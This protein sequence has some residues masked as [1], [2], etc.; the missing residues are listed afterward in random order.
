MIR[1]FYF[2][3]FYFLVSTLIFLF[4][5][6][7]SFSFFFKFHIP[8]SLLLLVISFLL[9][10][11][12]CSRFGGG[13]EFSDPVYDSALYDFAHYLGLFLRLLCAAF[14]VWAGLNGITGW[15]WKVVLIAVASY[16]LILLTWGIDR[17]IAKRRK[18]K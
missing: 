9:R 15:Y 16:L 12:V 5:G 8:A 4:K 13:S 7:M 2:P 1:N 3:N 17:L 6:T 10:S 14:L 18:K 11:A